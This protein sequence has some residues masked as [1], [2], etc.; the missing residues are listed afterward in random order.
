[1]IMYSMRPSGVGEQGSDTF[2]GW[3]CKEWG[4]E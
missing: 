2:K 3:L 1:M 4:Q